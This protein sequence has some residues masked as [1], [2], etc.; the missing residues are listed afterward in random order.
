MINFSMFLSASNI[1]VCIIAIIKYFLGNALL[2]YIGAFLAILEYLSFINLKSSNIFLAISIIFA[3]GLISTGINWLLALCL[4]LCIQNIIICTY[5]SILI[6]Y[7]LKKEK[8]DGRK[9]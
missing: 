2:L 6:I 8:L 1:I 3:I 4:C 9:K 5:R 7:H